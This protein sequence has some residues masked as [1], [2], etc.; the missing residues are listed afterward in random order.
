MTSKAIRLELT[1]QQAITQILPNWLALVSLFIGIVGISFAAIFI[2][3]SESE[4]SPYATIF[5]RLWISTASLG[6]V[7]GIQGIRRRY[8]PDQVEESPKNSGDFTKYIW[9]FVGYGTF[10]AA[11]QI[12]WAWSITQTSVA[13]STVLHNLTPL[14][15]C[16]LAWLLFGKHFDNKFIFGMVIALSGVVVIE[17]EDL[18]LATGKV[19][20]D[21]AAVVSAIL[22]A[23][24]LLIVE[25]LRTKFSA[26]KIL[27]W[28]SAIATLATIPILWLTQ[29]RIFPYSWKGWLFV[30]GLALVCQIIGQGLIVYSQ[31][32]LSSGFIAIA[33]LLDPV[34][35]SLQAWVIFSERLSVSC[36]IAFAVVLLGIYFAQLSKSAVKEESRGNS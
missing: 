29:E 15:T 6:L 4:L 22:V 20:G 30:I 18:Q 26:N 34:I 10:F 36:W 24:Y 27:M 32:M 17:F 1:K 5:N 19:Q 3:L 33:F 14:F 8:A 11:S 2:K 13:V 16:L 23:G 12:F 9:L 28:G 7:N 31:N 25:R 21:L 35:T